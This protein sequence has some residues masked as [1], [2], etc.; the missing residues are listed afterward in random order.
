MGLSIDN[1]V[2]VTGNAGEFHWTGAGA[3]KARGLHPPGK[4]TAK[5]VLTGPGRRGYGLTLT[6]IF[7]GTAEGDF[8]RRMVST[9]L[10]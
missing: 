6:S 2:S 9:P 4:K 7:L 5:L 10:A 1:P 3:C 8:G